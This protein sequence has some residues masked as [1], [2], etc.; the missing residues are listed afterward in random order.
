MDLPIESINFDYLPGE[1]E[2]RRVVFVSLRRYPAYREIIPGM[3]ISLD[4]STNP[5]AVIKSGR[6][7]VNDVHGRHI[8]I[9]VPSL[10]NIRNIFGSEIERNDPFTTVPR[11][12]RFTATPRPMTYNI[13]EQADLINKQ[14]ECPDPTKIRAQASGNY[15]HLRVCS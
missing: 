1:P 2:S 12:G 7:R 6:Y 9:D 15:M 14:K 13:Y 10:D 5:Y 8:V 11:Y 4:T 3:F